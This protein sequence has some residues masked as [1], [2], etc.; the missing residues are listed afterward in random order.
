MN[1]RSLPP[2][3][4]EWAG[5][6]AAAERIDV[7]RLKDTIE[8]VVNLVLAED[9]VFLD[10]L[11][12]VLESALVTPVGILDDIHSSHGSPVE[13]VV[14]ARLVRRSVAPYLDIVPPNLLTLI[15][16]LPE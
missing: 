7:G 6:E 3:L 11:P 10:S 16:D 5:A 9:A 14:A 12:E 13:L 1:Q 2:W 8:H 4:P 15:K